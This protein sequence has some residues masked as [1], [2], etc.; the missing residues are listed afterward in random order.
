MT[1]SS[2]PPPG[3]TPATALLVLTA[4][5]LAPL[6]YGLYW[7]GHDAME[8]TS[9]TGCRG[10]H[11]DKVAL[12]NAALVLFGA[13]SGGAALTGF[14]GAVLGRRAGVW[15]ATGAL[16]GTLATWAATIAWLYVSVQKA[17]FDF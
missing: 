10:N 12:V 6:V 17:S 15:A 9:A 2:P 14:A 3:R 4:V 7:L 13:P 11:D 8:C 16:L 5:L 1:L